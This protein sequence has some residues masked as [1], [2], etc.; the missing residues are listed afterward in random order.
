[1]MGVFAMGRFF[2]TAAREDEMKSSSPAESLLK[3]EKGE[4]SRRLEGYWLPHSVAT[5][6]LATCSDEEDL[7]WCGGAT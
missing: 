3:N 2:T 4:K 7:A 6:S 5:R 1:M